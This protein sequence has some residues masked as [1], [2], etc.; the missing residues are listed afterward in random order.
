VAELLGVTPVAEL[1]AI[2]RQRVQQLA[3]TDPEFP[4]F[5]ETF[6]LGACCAATTSRSGRR[7]TGREIRES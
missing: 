6:A 7:A 1:L 4:A 2:S 5:A 3:E